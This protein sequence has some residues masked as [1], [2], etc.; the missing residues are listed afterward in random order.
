MNASA[1]EFFQRFRELADA[2]WVSFEN[3]RDEGTL[4][5]GLEDFLAAAVMAATKSW[6]QHHES[7][8]KAREGAGMKAAGKMDLKKG[9][10]FKSLGG[11]TS[12]D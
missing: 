1:E 9:M 2:L 12:L 4:I 8:V 6:T 7:N 11:V 10:K 3:T 5:I